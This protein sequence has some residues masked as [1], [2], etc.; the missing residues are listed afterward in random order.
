MPNIRQAAIDTS[1]QYEKLGS[2][3][4]EHFSGVPMKTHNLIW[5]V[6]VP[7]YIDFRS[8]RCRALSD[9]RTHFLLFPKYHLLFCFLGC[10]RAQDVRMPDRQAAQKLGI[11]LMVKVTV[12]CQNQISTKC[13][14]FIFPGI[15][16]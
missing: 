9:A 16:Q 10:M 15:L 6:C 3:I 4:P 5:A 1:P 8:R 12:F 13:L 11:L 2:S 7:N 14:D